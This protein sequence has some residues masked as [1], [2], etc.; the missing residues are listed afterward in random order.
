MDDLGDTDQG[1]ASRRGTRLSAG[2]IAAY[3]IGLIVFLVFALPFLWMFASSFKSTLNIFADMTPFS[4]WTLLPRDATLDNFARL[5]TDKAIGRYLLNTLIIAAAQ[6]VVTLVVCSLAAFALSK[7]QFRGRSVLF[8]LVLVSFMIPFQ[9]ILIP[10]FDVVRRLGM[11][12]TYQAVFLPFAASAFAVFILRQAFQEIPVDTIDAARIDGAS[13]LQL[14]R[15]VCLPMIKPALA[16]V[17]L[18]TF[19]DAWNS[20]LWP[21]IVLN[22]P[23][24]QVVQIAIANTARPGLTPDFGLI[25]AGATI[26]TLPALIVFLALQRYF[27][28]GVALTGLKG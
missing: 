6:I 16:T 4:I 14:F 21:L 27:V 12:N 24:K 1:P 17:V 10:L 20:F 18:L 25:F 11:T 8:V 2:T 13:D 15:L 23:S 7:F 19:V 3:A 5:W 28:Q 22:D 9:A 26:A